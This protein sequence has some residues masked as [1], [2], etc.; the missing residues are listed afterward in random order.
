M[1]LTVSNYSLITIDWRATTMRRDSL[2]RNR[3]RDLG[4]V[5]LHPIGDGGTAAEGIVMEI[6]PDFFFPA[7]VV[8]S[9]AFSSQC[10]LSRRKYQGYMNQV[11][12]LL[13][14]PEIVGHQPVR[15]IFLTL[16]E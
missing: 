5:V 12:D 4:I 13:V 7:K 1:R 11:Q 10:P 9:S 2:N 8:L 14:L 16:S 6:L 15:T 3:T